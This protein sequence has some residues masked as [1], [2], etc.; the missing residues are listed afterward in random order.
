MSKEVAEVTSLNDRLPEPVRARGIEH[1]Q[2]MALSKSLFPGAAGD[3]ILMV[4]DYCMAR[5]LDPLKKPCHIV[6]MRV[7]DAQS[8]EFRWRDVVLPGIYEQRTTAQRTGQY[9]G[10]SAPEYG[11]F[12]DRFGVTAPEWCAMTVYRWN[13]RAKQRVDFPVRVYFAEAVGLKDNKANQR[14]AKA[15]IQMLTKCTEAAGLREAFPDELG[16]WQTAEEMEG[17]DPQPKRRQTATTLAEIVSQVEEGEFTEHEPQPEEDEPESEPVKDPGAVTQA[18]IERMLV[19]AKAPEQVVE[20][21]DLIR[22]LP[23][24][25]RRRLRELSVVRLREVS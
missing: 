24:G 4:W 6:P 21:M 8:G 23:E 3:S 9:L 15:P 14:W 22:E 16:G 25:E 20:A 5:G 17:H 12:A 13:E 7:K 19:A 2:W 18:E 10:H 1:A 11:E